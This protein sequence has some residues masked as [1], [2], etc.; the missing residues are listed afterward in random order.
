[1]TFKPS[2]ITPGF[3]LMWEGSRMMLPEH[4]T[5]L[6]KHRKESL[7]KTNP[8]LDEQQLDEISAV[9]QYS[10]QASAPITLT[11]F[12]EVQDQ[13]KTGVITNIDSQLKKLKLEN[14]GECEWIDFAR[15]IDAFS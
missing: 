7:K 10:Y 9:I 6:Q 8:N 11:V 3:N 2:K 13:H 4:V 12:G 1:M 14:N 5:M 15:I